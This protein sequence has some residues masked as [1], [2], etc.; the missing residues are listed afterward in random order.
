MKLK[1]A[2]RALSESYVNSKESSAYRVMTAVQPG[3]WSVQKRPLVLPPFLIPTHTPGEDQHDSWAADHLLLFCACCL[4]LVLAAV[5]SE[6]VMQ[7]LEKEIGLIL[8]LFQ[9]ILALQ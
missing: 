4:P 3:M 9:A 2:G 1:N 7:S 5:S 8:K 6:V